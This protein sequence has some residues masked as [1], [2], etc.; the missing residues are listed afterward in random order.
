MSG[1]CLVYGPENAAVCAESMVRTMA[2]YGQQSGVAAAAP[3]IAF[4]RAWHGRLPHEHMPEI[5]CD[6]I[7]VLV[8]GEIYDDRGVVPEP[9]ALIRDLYETGRIDQCA[10]LNG[11]FA[12]IICDIP[13]K[14]VHLVSDRVG[15][16]PLFVYNG[17]NHL[18][19]ASCLDALLSDTRIP[20]KLSLQ[21]LTELISFK[22][23]LRITPN[24][25]KSALCRRRRFGPYRT[26]PC[27]NVK[28]AAL[29]GETRRS[30]R[31]KW[32]SS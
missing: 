29:L 32:P 27:R 17:K 16:R 24:T 26:A 14:K 1:I 25:K 20:R 19:V 28:F 8:E 10:W 23:R 9:E 5:D 2:A 13:Q 11:T 18:A 31:P 21:G 15:S 12:A 7:I 30:E 3:S 6:A 22:R 4:G